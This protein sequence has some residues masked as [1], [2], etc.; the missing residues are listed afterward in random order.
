MLKKRLFQELNIPEKGVVT[1]HMKKYS[2]DARYNVSGSS[3]RVNLGTAFAPLLFDEGRRIE[4]VFK[5][6]NGV[7]EMFYKES[8]EPRYP[9]QISRPDYDKEFYYCSA[10][11]KAYYKADRCPNC[12]IATR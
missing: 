6:F 2:F 7:F 4:V 10:C 9:P 5:L 11:G 1:V 12:G 8:E 3:F